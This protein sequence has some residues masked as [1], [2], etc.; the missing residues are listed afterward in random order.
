MN[1]ATNQQHGAKQ[2]VNICNQQMEYVGIAAS[3]E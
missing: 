2:S 3:M 1:A